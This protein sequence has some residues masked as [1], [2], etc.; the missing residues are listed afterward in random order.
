MPAPK[1]VIIGLD[2]AT[3]DL[4]DQLIA[5]GVMP[6]LSR[7]LA[8]GARGRLSST[9]PPTTAPAW[10]TFSTG[11]NPGRHGVFDFR[12]R[13]RGQLR[14]VD[15]HSVRAPQVWDYAASAGC[16]TGV[17]NLP[18]TY[19]PLP[20]S[21]Y[22]IAG[23]MTPSGSQRYTY[24]PDLAQRLEAAI[25]PY[26]IYEPIPPRGLNTLGEVQFYLG[27][28]RYMVSQRAK[29]LYWLLS[30][31]PTDLIIAVFQVTDTLQH[32]FWKLLDLR[33]P[34]ADSKFACQVRPL[35]WECY[36][37]VDDILGEILGLMA[38]GGYLVVVSDHGF[39]PLNH[40]FYVN[41]WL[42][43]Q[44]LLVYS[45]PRVVA[46]KVMRRVRNAL[47]L[48]IANAPL[49][50]Q[51]ARFVPD[52]KKAI[53]WA[54]TRA[55]SGEVH[56][57]AIY[58]NVQG[59]EPA[60][61]VQPGM[62]YEAVRDQ[63]IDCAQTLLDPVTGQEI[64]C[65]VY[66]REEIYAGPFVEEAP[67]LAIVLDDYNYQVTTGFPL[68]GRYLAANLSPR[69]S[70][71]R[72]GIFVIDG[73]GV[74]PGKVVTSASIADVTPTVLYLMGLAVPE[75]LD[76]QVLL[77]ALEPQWLETHPLCIAPSPLR[78]IVSEESVY[79]ES[80]TADITARLQGLGYLD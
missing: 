5:Q 61:V 68:G 48:G 26:I 49:F 73:P 37:Q 54:R 33:D 12:Q 22:M 80:E 63:V 30:N 15:S 77:E 28:L 62:E 59:R 71:R 38:G 20:L 69:G 21:G 79:T 53:R 42:A 2:G 43:Q 19:P 45:R 29:A 75:G 4:L 7:L 70:H 58:I 3:F 31:H 13:T 16:T 74:C 50:N 17:I 65:R 6:N 27:R 32:L 76:G 52:H 44:G 47:R 9:I 56:Q 46:E 78:D 39:G 23:F 41:E 35:L 40:R 11:M 25:G 24:P 51:T 10:T 34:M 66:R 8:R 55:F 64:P 18:L 1:V 57:Q 36:R 67:D 60:G 14:W 72:D